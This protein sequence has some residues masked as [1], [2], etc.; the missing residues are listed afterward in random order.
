MSAI[1]IRGE[2]LKKW[3]DSK[4]MPPRNGE[5]L[6]AALGISQSL[7]SMIVNGKRQPSTHL[8]RKL[9]EITG[10]DVGDLF[11]FERA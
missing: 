3:L 6:A 9:C 11:T 5:E 2:V 4:T 7:F 1:R 8:Q 10:Y